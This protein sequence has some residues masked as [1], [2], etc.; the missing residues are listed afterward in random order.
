MPLVEEQTHLFIKNILLAMVFT[1]PS[2]TI[3]SYA[4]GL[5]R[6]Y[7]SKMSLTGAASPASICDI[8]RKLRIDLVVIGTQA[9]DAQK[10]DSDA[11]VGE[12]LRIVPC[13]MLI[14]GP[15][16]TAIELAKGEL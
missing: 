6:R 10:P 4:V 9:Q 5:A 7:G 13:P 12:I 2:E 1:E 3:L 15:R 14:V 16:V 11:A 8:T